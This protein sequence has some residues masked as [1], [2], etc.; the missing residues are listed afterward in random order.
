MNILGIN[1]SNI[2]VIIPGTKCYNCKYVKAIKTSNEK[3]NAGIIICG[4]LNKEVKNTNSY[5][6]YK[7]ENEVEF[8]IGDKV[9]VKNNLKEFF[10]YKGITYFENMYFDCGVIENIEYFYN[11][12][13]YIINNIAY[14]DEMIEKLN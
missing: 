4:K 8:N 14:S 5:C 7:C 2:N 10:K 9:K 1:N 6:K 13:L 3:I 11:K 12:K